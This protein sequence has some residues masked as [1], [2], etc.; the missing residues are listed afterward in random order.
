VIRVGL[1]LAFAAVIAALAT[2]RAVRVA[3]GRS[4]TLGEMAAGTLV[5]VLAMLAA[6]A[7]FGW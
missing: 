3:L 2:R 5:G 4:P 7:A 1:K 6:D